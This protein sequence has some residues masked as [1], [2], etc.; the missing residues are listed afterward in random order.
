MVRLSEEPVRPGKGKG[1]QTKDE[2]APKKDESETSP[3]ALMV[4]LSDDPV[5]PGK[6]TKDEEAP[7][8]DESETESKKKPRVP[9]NPWNQFQRRLRGSGIGGEKKFLAALYREE[10]TALR[11]RE[12]EGS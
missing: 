11:T 5:R 6:F 7:K 8:K 10:Q 9:K 2:E 3:C 1:S 12:G 4:K